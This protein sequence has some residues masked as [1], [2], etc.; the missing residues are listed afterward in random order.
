[1]PPNIYPYQKGDQLIELVE[2]SEYDK[3][4]DALRELQVATANHDSYKNRKALF[5]GGD[6]QLDIAIEKIREITQP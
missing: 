2:K 1:M 6:L 3:L 5:I 4:L